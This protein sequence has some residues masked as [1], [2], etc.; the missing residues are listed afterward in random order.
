MQQTKEEKERD[1][2]YENGRKNYASPSL[3]FRNKMESKFGLM[4][5]L[6]PRMHA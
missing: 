2:I 1:R 3:S 6:L 4:L 5:L